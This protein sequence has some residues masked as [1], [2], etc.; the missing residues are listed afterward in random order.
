MEVSGFL[1]AKQIITCVFDFISAFSSATHLLFF[2]WICFFLPLRYG[3]A[4]S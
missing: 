1:S 2:L 4:F 3:F